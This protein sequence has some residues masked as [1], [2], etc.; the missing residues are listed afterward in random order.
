MEGTQTQHATKLDATTTHAPDSEEL[1]QLRIMYPELRKAS[2]LIAD[3]GADGSERESI[4]NQELPNLHILAT[5]RH[6]RF[7]AA[8][9]EVKP[10][11]MFDAVRICSGDPIGFT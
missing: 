5:Y 10:S 2:R 3:P 8:L 1:K 7:Y 11:K 4:A 6:H 9:T